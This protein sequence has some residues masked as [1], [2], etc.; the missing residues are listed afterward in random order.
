MSCSGNGRT[1]LTPVAELLPYEGELLDEESAQREAEAS[2]EAL[3]PEHAVHAGQPALWWSQSAAQRSSLLV[4]D[5][6]SRRAGTGLIGQP[7][8]QPMVHPLLYLCIPSCFCRLA[9]EQHM[10]LQRKAGFFLRRD[11]TGSG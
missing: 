5:L 3:V 6:P 11:F 10:A 9:H 4:P 2:S 1:K 8:G 7:W